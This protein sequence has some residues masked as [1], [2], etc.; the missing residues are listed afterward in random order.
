VL[1]VDIKIAFLNGDLNEDIYIDKPQGSESSNNKKLVCK[2]NRALYGLK[3]ASR[4]WNQTFQEFMKKNNFTQNAADECVYMNRCDGRWCAMLIYVDDIIIVGK[5]VEDANWGK[6]ILADEFKLTDIGNL[7]LYLGVQITRNRKGRTM[8]L[9]QE[10]YVQ[11]KLM[12][13]GLSNAN[14]TTTPMEVGFLG[15]ANEKAKRNDVDGEIFRSMIGSLLYLVN[16]TRPDISNSVITLS[17]FLQ[18]PKAI[19]S[20]AAQRIFRYLKGTKDMALC[21][22]GRNQ[23]TSTIIGYSDADW[24]NCMLDR[25]SISIYVF[26]LGIGPISWRA[27]R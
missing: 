14:N 5:T 26:K 8:K 7:E 17:Q 20:S 12:Q 9:S 21:I 10:H 13:F 3:Q 1:K 2:L 27:K 22:G 4:C 18:R 19:H 16:W 11:E 23:D 15:D 25:K 6:R 24:G